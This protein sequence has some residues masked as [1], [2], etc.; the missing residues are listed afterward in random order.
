MRAGP[1]SPVGTVGFPASPARTT[2]IKALIDALAASGISGVVVD[3]VSTLPPGSAA[4]VS[5]SLTTGVLHLSFG[6]PSGADGA[7]GPTGEVSQSQLSND[8]VN[9]QN[10]AVLTTLPLTSANTNGV[11]LLAMTVSDP[12]TAGEVQTI[13]NKLDEFINAARR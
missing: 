11:S 3:D 12:P 13:A 5:A 7:T 2:A 10:A 9:T 6:L 1:E 4:T 8:L